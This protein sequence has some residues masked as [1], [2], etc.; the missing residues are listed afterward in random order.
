MGYQL[1]ADAP[2][3]SG[4]GTDTASDSQ[5]EHKQKLFANKDLIKISNL[6]ANNI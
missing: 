1:M 5:E 2:S 4:E 6:K 3:D